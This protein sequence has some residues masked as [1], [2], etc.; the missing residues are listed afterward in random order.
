MPF[1]PGQ[2]L[3]LGAPVEGRMLWR[4]YSITSDPKDE[5]SVSVLVR[6]VKGGAVSNWVCD[7][8]TGGSTMA[9]FPPAGHFNLVETGVPIALY[10]GGS[11]I[12]PVFSLAR[13]AL[14]SGAPQV[15]LFYAN[16]SAE[17]EMLSDQIDALAQAYP[18]RFNC[19]RWYDGIS[20]FPQAD[21]LLET[22]EAAGADY[23]YI[24]G[25]E[26]FMA[27]VRK[28]LDEAG[29][30][31]EKI[32]MEVFDTEEEEASASPQ[33]GDESRLTI[34]RDGD[35]SEI[36]IRAGQTI[37][38]ALLE[39]GVD[40]PHSCR[41]GECAA[42]MCHLVDGEIERME[43]SVLDEDD[44]EDGWILTCRSKIRSAA[45]TIRYE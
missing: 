33:G 4:C 11:G 31:P 29:T 36:S 8:L 14:E 41:A 2:Y 22:F 35:T 40:A 39:A 34:E 25:P 23:A 44:E 21:D 18:D 1:V 43:N 24:C 13:Q 38:S 15:S 32:R 28:T 20:G 37:L 16:R 10:A 19:R 42:C 6:R 45:A 3:T 27:L 30:A 12:A 5:D 7:N 26:P 9:V 17:T